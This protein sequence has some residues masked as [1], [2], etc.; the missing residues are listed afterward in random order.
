MGASLSD[1]EPS[2]Y[3]TAGAQAIQTPITPNIKFM[4]RF[5]KLCNVTAALEEIKGGDG[6]GKAQKL[7]N[8]CTSHICT[9]FKFMRLS[10]TSQWQCLNIKSPG[11][12]TK[13]SYSA[14]KQYIQ[15]QKAAKPCTWN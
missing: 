12:L 13:N 4:E 11:E 2:Q 1:C 9:H 14:P 7:L 15:L 6:A 8:I 3:G 5:S 10:Q